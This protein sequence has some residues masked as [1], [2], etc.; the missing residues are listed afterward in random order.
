MAKSLRAK[1]EALTNIVNPKRQ[2]KEWSKTDEDWA[3]AAGVGVKTL[4]RFWESKPVRPEIFISICKAVGIDD[5]QVVADIPADI[6]CKLEDLKER[7]YAAKLAKDY[8]K[9]IMLFYESS[10]L[11]RE[12]NK[13]ELITKEELKTN[14]EAVIQEI[15]QLQSNGN[16]ATAAHEYELTNEFVRLK[17]LLER[18]D[19][20]RA[21]TLTAEL[22]LT[23][24]KLDI[25]GLMT[26]ESIHLISPEEI[27]AI[28]NVWKKNS[29][30]IYG[31]SVQREIW[32]L[33]GGN[34]HSNYEV[35]K[36]FGQQV[37]WRDGA[38]YDDW[39]YFEEI[40]WSESATILG[41]LPLVPAGSI[42]WNWGFSSVGSFWNI[43]MDELGTC[44]I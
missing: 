44:G 9:A 13:D 12:A 39:R 14:N 43:F 4:Q 18:K 33:L 21:D 16:T 26:A 34:I 11:I 22:V 2:E 42:L 8:K 27:R 32:E 10:I 40:D 17:I 35:W 5:W 20:R 19:W 25:E 1:K 7:A 31:F 15:R 30:G 24:A 37:G 38:E 41:H 29:G 23:S 28:D 36:R 3:E 6:K